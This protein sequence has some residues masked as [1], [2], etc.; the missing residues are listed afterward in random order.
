[1]RAAEGSAGLGKKKTRLP[2][3][4]MCFGACMGRGLQAHPWAKAVLASLLLHPTVPLHCRGLSQQRSSDFS[5]GSSLRVLCCTESITSHYA[6]LLLV[7][8]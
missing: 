2:G 1:M 5:P 3:R 6:V 4:K 7:A 8:L